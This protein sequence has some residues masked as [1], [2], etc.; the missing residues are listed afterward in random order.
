MNKIQNP[1]FAAALTITSILGFSGANAQDTGT[2]SARAAASMGAQQRSLSPAA[3]QPMVDDYKITVLSDMVPGNRTM[4][5]WGFAALI[6][7]T[8]AGISKR[9]FFDTGANPLT[10][11]AN[12]RTLNIGICDIEDVVL[13]HNHWDHTTGLN[14]LRSSCK[15]VNPS[16]FKN[17]YI[18]GE[19]IFW[20]R[21]NA[22]TNAN[23]MV[24][25]KARYLAQGGNF[26][27]NGQPAAQFLGLPGVW[28]TGK[29]ARKHDEKTY[30]GTP[31]IQ[32]PSG[33]LSL[34]KMPEEIALVINTATG[35]VVVTGC[36]HAGIINTIEAAK[37]ILGGAQPPVTIVG[38][39]HFFPLPLGEENTEGAEG[40][41]IWEAHQMKHHGVV[42][43]MGSHCTGLER[44]VYLRDFLRLDD[45]AAVFGSVGTVLSMSGGFRYTLPAAV[46]APLRPHWQ[47][48][49]QSVACG[50]K[51][52]AASCQETVSGWN[53]ILLNFVSSMAQ[54][55]AIG[56][57][58]QLMTV[59]QY[60]AARRT[61]GI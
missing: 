60:L 23:I 16:A 7:V 15:E 46:N 12:A 61:A 32:D 2:W 36:A 48:Q 19:E 30:P 29:I 20:P 10:A 6:E 8:S 5:E 53:Y 42:R 57:S 24:D 28:L 25:E 37:V 59:Q 33:N 38:G 27:V 56:D 40:T 26:I 49:L 13:S 52:P 43:M 1:M 9:F 18:G 41:V 14:T 54:N 11:L 35:M 22:G 50:T 3:N 17:A 34:D 47:T 39:I 45:S 31:N 4:A 58:S 51:P 44:F 21:I 55:L